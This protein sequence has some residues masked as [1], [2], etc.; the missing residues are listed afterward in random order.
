MSRTYIVASHAHFAQGL[1]EGASFLAGERNDVRVLN[2]FVDG[3]EDIE[4]AAQAALQASLA[5]DANADIVVLTDLMGGSV[6]N[7]FTKL[8]LENSR[9]FVVTN[10]NLPLLLSLLLADPSEPTEQLLRELTSDASMR[11]V[12]VNDAVKPSV[13][14]ETDEDF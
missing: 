9:I 4:Q 5:Q 8:L 2:A 10:M 1:V 11:P 14:E 3:T 7:E 6:N 12:F 13:Q